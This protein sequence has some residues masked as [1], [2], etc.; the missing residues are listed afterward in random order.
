MEYWNFKN[1]YKDDFLHE[2][3]VEL[4]EETICKFKDN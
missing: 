4:G 2:L 1:F 3:D